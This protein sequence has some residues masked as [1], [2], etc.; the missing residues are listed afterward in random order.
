MPMCD[1][2]KVAKQLYGNY[3]SAWVFSCKFAP[4]LQNTFVK[5][6][7]WRAASDLTSSLVGNTAIA[8]KTG[9]RDNKNV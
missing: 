2:N 7:L 1:F 4:Y 5:Q 8:T 9:P 6:H 3:T